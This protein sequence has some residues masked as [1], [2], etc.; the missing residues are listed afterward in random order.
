[1]Q[2]DKLQLSD[3]YNYTLNEKNK[4]EKNYIQLKQDADKLQRQLSHVQNM[5]M[6]LQ[7]QQV[8]T[9]ARESAS[10]NKMHSNV[11]VSSSA[12]SPA[13]AEKGEAAKKGHSFLS[14]PLL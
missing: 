1:L 5:N 10:S 12:S 8:N 3:E 13:T 2:N 7:Q 6:A 14:Q 4:I 11:S 9:G